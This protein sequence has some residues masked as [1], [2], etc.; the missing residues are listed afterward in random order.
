MKKT[1]KGLTAEKIC[2]GDFGIITGT[3]P[4]SCFQIVANTVTVGMQICSNPPETTAHLWFGN[5]PYEPWA[6]RTGIF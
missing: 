1:Y 5:N 6:P 4:Q 2:F 3:V